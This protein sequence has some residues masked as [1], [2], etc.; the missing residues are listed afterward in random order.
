MQK[1]LNIFQIIISIG[2]IS[3]ILLQSQGGGLGESFGGGGSSYRTRRGAEKIIYYATI[4]LA[5]LFI[6][7]SLLRLLI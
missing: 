1:I 6:L 4:V 3:T 2:L 5:G 7:S